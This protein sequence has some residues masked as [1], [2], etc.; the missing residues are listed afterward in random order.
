LARILLIDDDPVYSDMAKQRLE[1][2]GH[3]VGV[4][5]G[6]FGATAAA[7]RPG[8]D[9]II[10]DVFMPALQGPDLIELI[11]QTKPRVRAKIMFCSSMDEEALR[12]LAIRHQADGYISKSA[13]RTDFLTAVGDVLQ[14]SAFRTPGNPGETAR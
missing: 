12:D 1:R 6:P 5:L 14:R 13:A 3:E 4:H 2:A 10:L 7:K 9:L 8:L 11:H